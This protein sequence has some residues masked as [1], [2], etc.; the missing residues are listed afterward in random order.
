MFGQTASHKILDQQL[1]VFSLS[2][3]YYY[4]TYVYIILL[5]VSVVVVCSDIISLETMSKVNNR[6]RKRRLVST[7]SGGM[8]K[9]DSYLMQQHRDNERL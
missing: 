6:R 3:K 1:C 8:P 4:N 2:V 9:C 5:F 7:G